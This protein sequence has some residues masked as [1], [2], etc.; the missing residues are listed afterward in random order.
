MTTQR[1]GDTEARPEGFEA[2][3]QAGFEWISEH[4]R[5]VLFTI[6]GML[7][8]GLVVTIVY[9]VQS[10]QR[11]TATR[12]LARIEAKFAESM[13]GDRRL[14][15]IPEPANADQATRSRE[16]A[17]G[18]LDRFIENQGGRAVDLATVRAAEMELDLGRPDAAE[19][20]LRALT[21]ELTD[22][23]PLRGVALRLLAVVL[24]EQDKSLDAAGVYAE[25]AEL[26]SY[27]DP[28]ALWLSAAE[29]YERAGLSREAIDAYREVI[30]TDPAY[31]GSSQVED[32][33]SV[34]EIRSATA[35]GEPPGPVPESAPANP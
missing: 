3:L 15:L 20:R 35:S 23:D 6:G 26:E 11:D 5:Q 13:G 4:P 9:E 29:S 22:A 8:V 7:L 34:L 31:A 14:A 1:H 32:R 12:E 25:A 30:N 27:P 16:E 19:T 2:R 24:E 17:L 33:I 10:R 21:G 28:G 18:E